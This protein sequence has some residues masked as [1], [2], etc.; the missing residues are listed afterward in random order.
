MGA[1]T[2]MVKEIGEYSHQFNLAVTIH[3]KITPG[4]VCEVV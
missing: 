1:N 4:V 3:I 2:F